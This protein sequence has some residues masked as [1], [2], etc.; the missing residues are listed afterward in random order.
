MYQT[1]A[2]CYKSLYTNDGHINYRRASD[3]EYYFACGSYLYNCSATA[4][5]FLAELRLVLPPRIIG[6][7]ITDS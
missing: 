2:L 5:T 6:G 7:G 3:D 1:P 4:G